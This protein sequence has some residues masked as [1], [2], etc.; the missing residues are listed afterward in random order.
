MMHDSNI[1]GVH[2]GTQQH[3]AGNSIGAGMPAS[4][5][6]YTGSEIWAEELLGHG[7]WVEAGKYDEALA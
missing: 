7:A 3:D 4:I 1:L 5:A 2:E 6:D